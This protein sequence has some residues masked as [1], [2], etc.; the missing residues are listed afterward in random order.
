[1]NTIVSLI[2]EADVLPYSE[3]NRGLH[4]KFTNKVAN[5]V[6]QHDLLNFRLIGQEEYLK[7]VSAVMLK[8]P[9]V[10]APNRERRLQVLCDKKVS[11]SRVTQLERDKRFVITAMKK[12][13]KVFSKDRKTSRP[14]WRELPLALCDSTGD[15]IGGN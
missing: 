8:N 6:Q 4:N 15:P 3:H 5:A 1:M 12:K 11:K 14:T 9:S 13:M 7:R 2:Q 10:H